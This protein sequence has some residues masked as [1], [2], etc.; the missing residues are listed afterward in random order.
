MQELADQFNAEQDAPPFIYV[1]ARQTP[2]DGPKEVSKSLCDAV[3][4]RDVLLKL[5]K[6]PNHLK[7]FVGL[8]STATELETPAAGNFSSKLAEFIQK[9]EENLDNTIRNLKNIFT[10]FKSLP[11]KPVIVIGRVV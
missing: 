7:T 5:S 6:Y 8:V 11:R 10:A 4:S 1:N 9:D 3:T 2:V